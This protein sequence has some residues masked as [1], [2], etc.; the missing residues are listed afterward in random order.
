MSE[1]PLS[2]QA[3]LNPT[4]STEF[5]FTLIPQNLETEPSDVPGT[6]GSVSTT[7]TTQEWE[8]EVEK[9]L[10]TQLQIPS[11]KIVQESEREENASDTQ[12]MIP[13]TQNTIES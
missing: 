12:P 1:Q 9:V 8:T 6:Q 5:S 2:E 10:E 11:T 7:Q 3:N 4:Q 13:S